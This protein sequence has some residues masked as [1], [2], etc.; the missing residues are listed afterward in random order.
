[1]LCTGPVLAQG[2]DSVSL[3]IYNEDLALIR[4]QRALQLSK[5]RQRV[6][7]KG[8]SG[9]IIAPSAL[10][11]ANGVDLIEQ[12]F[13]F[14][15]LTP[16]SLLEKSLGRTVRL[17]RTNPASGEEVIEQAR[18]LAVNDG[19]VLEL[20]DRIETLRWDA[21]PGRILFSAIPDS[22]RAEPTLS[23]I[24]DAEAA[25]PSQARLSYLSEGLSWRADYVAEL[26]AEET[27][28]ALQ[29]LV[30]LTNQSGTA[31]ADAQV[32]LVAGDVN[33]VRQ[34]MRPAA[35]AEVQEMSVTAR[36][37][38]ER[39]ALG[40]YHLY[41]LPVR[42]DLADQQTKQVGFLSAPAVQVRK[43]YVSEWY[44][45]QT[46]EQP[47]HADVQLILQNRREDG[48]GQPLPQGILRVYTQDSAG[49]AQFL[50]ED[51]VRHTPQGGTVRAQLGQAF[52]VTVKPTR[53]AFN[54]IVQSR[55]RRVY[56]VTQRYDLANAKQEAVTITLL[57]VLPEPDWQILEQSA[58]PEQLDD[59]RL[60]WQIEVQ[61]KGE[62]IV[63]ARFRIGR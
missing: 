56:E 63:T 18:V 46:L 27:S 52:D 16:R 45:F 49:R 30:T 23:M 3:T 60:R 34:Q 43:D 12:N 17:A 55:D 33:R 25:G 9:R 10:L 15:L 40:D 29:G 24:L 59:R 47:D 53:T 2:P 39:E 50:G 57:Q 48:L 20:E 1:M 38:V 13:D 51:R 62:A 36:R 7:L 37:D 31:Y 26:N 41:T 28:L 54:Q 4:E 21:V 19:V 6:A 61:A 11:S 14:D 22:L 35:R 42:T 5:G 44:G 8:V 32:Q 58:D